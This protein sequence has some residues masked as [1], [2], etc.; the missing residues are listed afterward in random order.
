[1]FYYLT[2]SYIH[3]LFNA[4]NLQIAVEKGNHHKHNTVSLTDKLA[5]QHVWQSR[6]RK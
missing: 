6:L 4:N 5:R 3:I 1:M 2:A